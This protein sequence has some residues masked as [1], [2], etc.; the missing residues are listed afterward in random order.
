MSLVDKDFTEHSA[1]IKFDI[2]KNEEVYKR[3]KLV[4]RV[5]MRRSGSSKVIEIYD[6]ES[7]KLKKNKVYELTN[8]QRFVIEQGFKNSCINRILKKT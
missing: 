2:D 3:G 5:Q 7:K 6:D 8:P 4:V 1:F